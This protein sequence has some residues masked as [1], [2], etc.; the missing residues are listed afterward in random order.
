MR[1]TQTSFLDL[2][3]RSSGPWGR[4]QLRLEAFDVL[5]TGGA[6]ADAPPPA[7]PAFGEGN[8]PHSAPQLQSVVLQPVHKI[9]AHGKRI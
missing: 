7:E 6:T 4:P 9:K 3:A 1:A 8:G 5:V 2:W